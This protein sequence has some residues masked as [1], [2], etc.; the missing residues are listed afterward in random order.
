MDRMSPR[1]IALSASALILGAIGSFAITPQARAAT[2]P[3]SSCNDSGTGSLRAVVAAA[4]SGDT[5][6]LR[7]LA[8]N[9]IV[10]TGGQIDVPQAS[11]AIRGPGYAR[12][13]LSGNW[14][15]RVFRHTGAG[16]LAVRGLTVEQGQTRADWAEGGCLWS[17]GNIDLNDVHVRHCAAYAKFDAIDGALYAEGDITLFFSALYS[18]GAKGASSSGGAL[19]SGRPLNDGTFKGGHVRMHRT[20][21]FNNVAGHG[22]AMR[23]N[24]GVDMTYSTV[25]GN[26]A[27]RSNGA[28]VV[29]HLN[30]GPTR[31]AYSTI[32][33][34]SA[35]ES[36][37]TF[38]IGAGAVIYNSTITGNSSP[39]ISVG[40]LGPGSTIANS[41][42]AF[43]RTEGQCIA[44]LL[45]I[46]T[47][48]LESSI[49]ARNINTC[50]GIAPDW[51]IGHGGGFNRPSAVIGSD[52]LVEVPGDTPL[53]SDTITGVNPLLGPLADNGGRTRTLMP[54]S[55]SPALDRGNNTL[56]LSTDQ[57]GAGFP[58]VKGARADIGAVER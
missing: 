30:G 46:E 21:I 19:M 55:N 45:V 44:A 12:F 52:N 43:N 13:T 1:P 28:L 10:L 33:D 27:R 40:H 29:L 31:I 3:V 25:S 24:N 6:D 35:G 54:A 9:R 7:G 49:V 56:G 50:D 26:R 38:N 39:F 37:G 8:C 34:N 53:P 16:T 41:T 42:I 14:A 51:D 20:R 4:N 58:R 5:I 15:S 11:L 17:F 57:R 47:L 36:Y 32:S 18:N 23:A 2:L 22:G 48:H